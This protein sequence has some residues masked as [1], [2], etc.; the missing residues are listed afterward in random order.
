MMN[1]PPTTTPFEAINK[2]APHHEDFSRSDNCQSV[3]T[4]AQTPDDGSMLLQMERQWN[5]ALKTHNNVWIESNFAA[6]MT[7]ISSG[8]GA[9]HSKSE[10]IVMMKTD[11]TVYELL[12]LSDLKTRV[13]GNAG[14]VTGINHLKG[15]DEQGQA[16]EVW[17]AFTD[18]YI[19]REGRWQVWATQHTRMKP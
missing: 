8:N 6:D 12:E 19:K 11:K 3:T 17:L 7:D 10:D 1:D 2:R 9:L 16:F 15:H 14:I 4:L 18:T 13:E 5:D